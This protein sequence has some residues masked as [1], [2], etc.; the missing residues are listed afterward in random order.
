MPTL[1]EQRPALPVLHDSLSSESESAQTEFLRAT[2]ATLA[3]TALAAVAGAFT[4][5]GE[6]GADWA[7][8]IAAIAFAGALGARGWIV[9]RAPERRWYDARAGA[10]SAKTLAWQYA[11]GGGR[12]PLSLADA[13]RRLLERLRELL[14]DLEDDLAPVPSGSHGQLTDWM[15]QVRSSAR[16]ERINLY[17][18]QRVQDQI[19]WYSAKAAE[20][21]REAAKW[22]A[23]TLAVYAAGVVVAVL[24]AAGVLGFDALG[25]AAA[26]AGATTA[27]LQTKDFVGLS[28][29][30]SV[31]AQ[32]LKA[33]Q[34]ESRLVE[35]EQGW[36]RFVED[37]EDAI[38]REHTLW[39]AKRQRGALRSAVLSR[40]T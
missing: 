8:V 15:R 5:G 1:S 9:Y 16:D 14:R 10:E 24:K 21:R 17:C 30:Y 22:N 11:V 3:L 23:I 31:T 20:N 35:D 32:E 40:R 12:F 34:D 28:E 4:I 36:V 18:A 33:V 25:I 37:A 39:R 29:A 7:G 13:D 38:S 2:R 26:A 19:D 6:T 27:W